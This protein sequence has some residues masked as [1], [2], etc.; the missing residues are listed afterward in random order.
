MVVTEVQRPSKSKYG[1]LNVQDWDWDCPTSL[2]PH[3]LTKASHE[4]S[5][6][7]GV[8][9]QSRLS[10]GGEDDIGRG[11]ES[12]PFCSQSTVERWRHLN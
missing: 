4:A 5:R 12:S 6:T 7:R 11:R 9:G 3:L 2:L 1:L 8:R 10:M